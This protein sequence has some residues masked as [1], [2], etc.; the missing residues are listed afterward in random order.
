[1]KNHISFK[2]AMSQSIQDGRK[3]QTRR[4]IKPQPSKLP[5][6]WQW[7][8]NSKKLHRWQGPAIFAA[9]LETITW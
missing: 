1:M 9:E 6:G 5:D 7:V 2:P 4:L 8:G 3:T